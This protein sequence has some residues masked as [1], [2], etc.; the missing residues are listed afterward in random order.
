MDFPSTAPRCR[1]A[2]VRRWCYGSATEYGAGTR[3]QTSGVRHERDRGC[4][5]PTPAIDATVYM[6]R[7]KLLYKRQPRAYVISS[8]QND[9]SIFCLEMVNYRPYN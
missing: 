4:T 6:T 2:V 8:A 5:L 1:A 3:P 9:F 7:G